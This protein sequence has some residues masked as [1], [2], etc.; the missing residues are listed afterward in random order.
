[1]APYAFSTASVN[2]L[3]RCC[4]P[5]GSIAFQL[6]PDFSLFQ[7]RYKRQT[8]FLYRNMHPSCPL[9]NGEEKQREECIPTHSWTLIFTFCL[10]FFLLTN[11]SLPASSNFFLYTLTLS[12]QN[13]NQS[14]LNFYQPVFPILYLISSDKDSVMKVQHS[15]EQRYQPLTTS[16]ALEIPSLLGLCSYS[17]KRSIVH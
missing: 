6:V 14:V 2:R 7:E 11:E 17:A 15:S 3:K 5:S 16:R 10:F 8:W 13:T 1:M 9:L 12:L 4:M